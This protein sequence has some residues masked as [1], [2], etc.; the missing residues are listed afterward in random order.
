MW[1]PIETAPKDG[2]IVDLWVGGKRHANCFWACA[3]GDNDGSWRQQWAEYDAS[4]FGVFETVGK[5]PTH[6]MPPPNPPISGQ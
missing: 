3:V 2:T 1:Q 4:S 5:E 6:W